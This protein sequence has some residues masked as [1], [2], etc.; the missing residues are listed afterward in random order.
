MPVERSEGSRSR[1]A[2]DADHL[3]QAVDDLLNLVFGELAA[4]AQREGDVFADGD[5][6]E[7]RAVLEDHGDLAADVLQLLLGEAADVFA[8]DR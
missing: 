7:E 6:V 8:G 2:C 4:L 3:E 5:R 1:H